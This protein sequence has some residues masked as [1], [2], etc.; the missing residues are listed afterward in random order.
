MVVQNEVPTHAR[1]LIADVCFDGLQVSC[2]KRIDD[3]NI[4]CRKKDPA[5]TRAGLSPGGNIIAIRKAR[6]A[7]AMKDVYTFGEKMTRLV[8]DT[9]I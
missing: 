8:Y 5:A 4:E 1:V 9:I 7:S 6:T 3:C 2:Q